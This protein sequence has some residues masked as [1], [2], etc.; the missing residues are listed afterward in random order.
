MVIFL[1]F[2][3]S[4]FCPTGRKKKF[5]TLLSL[6][7]LLQIKK[8]FLSS[9]SPFLCLFVLRVRVRVRVAAYSKLFVVVVVSVFQNQRSHTL[10]LS[11]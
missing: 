4:A 7:L 10:T 6:S 3:F 11:L 9:F 8:I 2:V 1:V 5:K